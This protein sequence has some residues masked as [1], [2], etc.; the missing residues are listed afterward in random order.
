[1]LN[2]HILLYC[3]EFKSFVINTRIIRDRRISSVSICTL[4]TVS[5]LLAALRLPL[6]LA[7]PLLCDAPTIIDNYCHFPNFRGDLYAIGRRCRKPQ[8]KTYDSDSHT[9]IKIDLNLLPSRNAVNLRF[10]PFTF[11][12]KIFDLYQRFLAQNSNFDTLACR[13]KIWVICEKTQ[14]EEWSK[15][16]ETDFFRIRIK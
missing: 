12:K 1:M 13:R 2:R 9:H 4:L 16:E 7:V 6:F 11:P 10:L 14:I 3:H 15:K 5:L 8:P